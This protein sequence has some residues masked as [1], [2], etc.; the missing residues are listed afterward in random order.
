MAHRHLPCLAVQGLRV[1][2]WPRPLEPD[3]DHAGEGKESHAGLRVGL[4][5]GPPGGSRAGQRPCKGPSPACA[6]GP[7]SAGPTSSLPRR[8]ATGLQPTASP[9]ERPCTPPSAPG[10]PSSG[11]CSSRPYSQRPA[12]STHDAGAK[13]SKTSWWRATRKGP[14]PRSPHC[15][16]LPWARGSC[17]R[18][19]RQPPGAA[20]RPWSAM[21][22][23]RCPRWWPCCC[24]A[25]ACGS[26]CPTV[27][28]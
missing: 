13:A 23:A 27:T 15:W 3:P 26:S 7:G 10:R 18:P 5:Q 1:G 19:P 11:W 6:R 25:V 21:R 8:A 12:F 20:S 24:W 2:R 14:L 4:Q 16:P 17:S 22:W 9:R 28:R